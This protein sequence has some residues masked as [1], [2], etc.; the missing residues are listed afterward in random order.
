MLL[1]RSGLH[2]ACNMQ[3][4]AMLCRLLYKLRE[5][6]AGLRDYWVRMRGCQAV[7]V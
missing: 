4:L 2:V 6:A 1:Y 5:S 7:G 3:K